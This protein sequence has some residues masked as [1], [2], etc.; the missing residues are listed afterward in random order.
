M[1]PG[2]YILIFL[3]K[4]HSFPTLSI[5]GSSGGW[6]GFPGGSDGKESKSW[7]LS[8]IKPRSP[9]LQENSLPAKPPG[10]PRHQFN[11]WV[12]KIPWRRGWLPIPV[13][14]P[15]EFHEQRSLVRYNPWITQVCL[16]HPLGYS[17]R[18]SRWL[19]PGQWDS[20]LGERCSLSTRIA[21]PWR[22]EFEALPAILFHN[23][24]A[25]V[26]WIKIQTVSEMEKEQILT[27]WW[28][29]QTWS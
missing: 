11:P 5:F 7:V 16:P 22:C 14:W 25:Y 12:G 26:E 27:L 28:A 18:R 29:S 24:V 13:F 4:A 10:R 17:S 3:W 23:G 6:M 8:G 9:T 2:N 20:V 19:K 15:G 1:P 21:I